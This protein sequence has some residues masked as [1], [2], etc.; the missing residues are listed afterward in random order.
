MS[1][2]EISPSAWNPF[3]FNTQKGQENQK[4][5]RDVPAI[6]EVRGHRSSSLRNRPD[7]KLGK[8]HTLCRYQSIAR[9]WRGCQSA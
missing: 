7:A 1:A 3:R 4:R 5:S 2:L 6:E 9:R 8:S